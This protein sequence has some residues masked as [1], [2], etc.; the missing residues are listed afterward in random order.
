MKSAPIITLSE[1]KFLR[2]DRDPENPNSA[3]LIFAAPEYMAKGDAGVRLPLDMVEQIGGNI[4]VSITATQ[5]KKVQS[6][7]TANSRYSLE[8]VVG[9]YAPNVTAYTTF[10]FLDLTSL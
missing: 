7:V 3:K 9:S 5:F 2:I 10:K 4:K 8:C 6:L 1:C